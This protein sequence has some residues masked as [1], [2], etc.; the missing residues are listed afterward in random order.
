MFRK[1]GGLFL[2]QLTALRAT[3]IICVSSNLKRKLWWGSDKVSIIP[4]GVDLQLFCPIGKEQARRLLGWN[5]NERIVLFNAGGE[6]ELKGLALAEQA[7]NVAERLVGSTRLVVLNGDVPPEDV[8]I[9]INAADCVLLS[10]LS[11]G[12][13]NIVK[14]ALACSVPVV[15]VNVGDVEE[16]LVGVSPSALTNER[17]PEKLGEALA[18][19]LRLGSRSNGRQL[20]GRISHDR[21]SNAI[22]DV[23]RRLVGKEVFTK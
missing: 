20:V 4:S 8:P 10:S 21:I 14:E 1:Y 11:E 19:V 5:E 15:A 16:L 6:P 9:R 22:C 12:S 17:N 2:S 18:S 3:A 23:Y 13:P 7:L